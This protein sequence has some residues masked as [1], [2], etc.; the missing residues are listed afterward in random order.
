MSE[1]CA[2]DAG[3]VRPDHAEAASSPAP[4]RGWSA[5]R[6]DGVASPAHQPHHRQQMQHKDSLLVWGQ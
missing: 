6:I 2:A 1:H 3:S 5:S 4:G